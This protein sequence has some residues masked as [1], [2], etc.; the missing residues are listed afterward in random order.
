MLTLD[1]VA[2]EL[3]VNRAGVYAMVRRGEL[4][5][6]KLGGRG[7]WRVDRR[8]LEAFIDQARARTVEW[9]AQHPF[10]EGKAQDEDPADT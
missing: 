9:I 4:P 1:Q 3:Q 8:D 7:M 5:A 6:L 10:V 2:E